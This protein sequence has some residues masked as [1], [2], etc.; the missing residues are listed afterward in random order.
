[1]EKPICGWRGAHVRALSVRT[2]H[3]TGWSDSAIDKLRRLGRGHQGTE[4][5]T[6]RQRDTSRPLLLHWSSMDADTKDLYPHPSF[7][8]NVNV[9]TTLAIDGWE[10]G[11]LTCAMEKRRE[12]CRTQMVSQQSVAVFAIKGTSIVPRGTD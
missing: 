10:V 1:M 6:P 5:D 2:T 11:N 7:V 3:Q 12:V 8:E 4:T 9:A